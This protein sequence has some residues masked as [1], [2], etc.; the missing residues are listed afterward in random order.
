[1]CPVFDDDNG[2]DDDDDDDDADDADADAED[3]AMRIWQEKQDRG[4]VL[5]LMMA[6]TM[7]M[8]L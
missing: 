4:C 1:M 7:M 3:D 5:F 8:M 6:M 2:D